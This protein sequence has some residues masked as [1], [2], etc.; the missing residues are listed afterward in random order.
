MS[1]RKRRKA[2][3]PT[4]VGYVK[5]LISHD[6]LFG[7]CIKLLWAKLFLKRVPRHFWT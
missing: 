5:Q 4:A 1:V 7:L 6:A 3:K 2:V